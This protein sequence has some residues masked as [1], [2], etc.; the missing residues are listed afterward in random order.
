[1]AQPNSP[2]PLLTVFFWSPN[3]NGDKRN[4]ASE[5]VRRSSTTGHATHSNPLG[6]GAPASNGR[7]SRL[8]SQGLGPT[9]LTGK[10]GKGHYPFKVHRTFSMPPDWIFCLLLSEPCFLITVISDCRWKEAYE[11][12][13]ETLLHSE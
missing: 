9:P 10:A 7:L 8:G 5:S 1:M 3:K 11:R 2:L 4:S 6:D 13:I 12:K